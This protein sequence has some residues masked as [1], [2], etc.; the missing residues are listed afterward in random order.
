MSYKFSTNSYNR[1]N[2]VNDKLI[3]LCELTLKRSKIDFGIAWMGGLRTAKEQNKL[4]LDGNSTKDGYKKKS[5]HQSG[6]A[7]DFQPYVN[8]KLDRSEHNYLIII[9]CFFACASELGINIR[10]GL[11]WDNDQVFILDQNFQDGGHLELI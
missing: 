9:G 6:M 5:K 4:F 11:N 2:T 7:I 3:Q 1:L 8:N 10:S